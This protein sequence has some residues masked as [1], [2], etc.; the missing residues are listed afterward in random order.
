M[1][2]EFR[3]LGRVD[4][5]AGLRQQAELA[6]R[7]RAGEVGDVVLLLEHDPVY[8]IGRTPDKSSLANSQPLPYPV[9]EIS[10]GG[11]ATYHGP[12]Q[13]VGY[14]ILDL[15]QFGQDLHRYL[16]AIE[17]GLVSACRRVSVLAER[18]D[19]LTGV[20][21][22]QRKLASIGVG[23]RHWISQHGFALNVTEESLAGFAPIIPCGL[24]GVQM[25]CLTREG[26]SVLSVEDFTAHIVPSFT[27]SLG[28][29]R[30]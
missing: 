3:W 29:L 24:A 7:R 30:S 8:T 17:D 21:A 11:Q 19:N 4:Y 13:L 27:D 15:T 25:T 2:L 26:A 14:P 16:R 5:A 9:V 23:V 18:R 20:W 10:R 22:G 28:A 6:A 1:S 12:G